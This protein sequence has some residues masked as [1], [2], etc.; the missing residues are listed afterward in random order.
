[1]R[2]LLGV[3]SAFDPANVQQVVLYA[4]TYTYYPGYYINGNS[5]VLP[6][7]NQILPVVRAS[8]P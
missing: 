5:V 2:S 3:A 4:P 7:W 1:V 6:H 8:F